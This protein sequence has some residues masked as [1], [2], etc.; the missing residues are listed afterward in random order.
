MINK[1]ST[2]LMHEEISMKLRFT[3]KYTFIYCGIIHKTSKVIY[4]V[5]KKKKIK[6]TKERRKRYHKAENKNNDP[7]VTNGYLDIIE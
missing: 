3:E 6:A 2:L 1:F 5:T 4:F 7:Y